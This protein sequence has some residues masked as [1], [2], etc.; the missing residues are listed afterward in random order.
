MSTKNVGFRGQRLLLWA[1]GAVALVS[2]ALWLAPSSPAQ[3]KKKEAKDAKEAKA[4]KA[5]ALDQAVLEKAVANR[6]I[7]KA[8]SYREQVNFINEQIEKGWLD[9]KVLPSPRCNDYEFIRRASLDIIGRIPTIAEIERF[10]RDPEDSRR[11]KLIDRLVESPECAD[12]FATIWTVMLLTRTGSGKVFKEQLREWLAGEL[13]GTDKAPPDWSKITTALLT[14]TGETNKNGAVNYILH[15]VGDEIKNDATANGKWDMI[16]VTSRTTRLFLGI[17]TQCVQCHDHP[18]NG[19]W[20]QHHFWGINAF[21]RQVDTNGRPTM[22][23]AKKKVKGLPTQQFD[24]HDNASYNVKGLVPYERRNGVLLVTDPTF[25][26]GKKM[27]KNAQITR[28]EQL[29]KFIT[30]SPSFAKAYVNRMWGHFMGKSFTKDS[31]DDF[32][33]HNPVSHPELLDKL[34]EEFVK[35]NHNPKV[36]ISWICNSR[37]YGLSS[38][39]NRYNDKN[40]DETLFARMLLKPMT[41]EQMFDSLMTATQ[42]KVSQAKEDKVALK[43][44]WL[45]LL[46]ANFGNDEGE[47][48]SFN[49]TVV[50]ALLLMNGKDINDAVMDK[51]NGTVAVVLKK[52]AFS[53]D[54]APAAIEELYLAALSRPPYT[55]VSIP[56]FKHLP[57]LSAGKHDEVRDLLSQKMFNFSRNPAAATSPQF[58]TGYYQDIFWALLNSNEFILNH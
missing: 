26:D 10:M 12:N 14:A 36:V 16:P 31:V 17:R 19:E 34:A 40:E 30:K 20:G 35:Y 33:E 55:T 9:N 23:V 37:S 56:S 48:G 58:W 45:D 21:F 1:A 18:F 15:H 46:T 29:A 43:E 24:V 39:A 7:D 44:Q 53:K 32:G 27:P 57:G 3:G 13:Q 6:P 38:V 47:E 50:Q 41:P 51:N 25:L 22:M 49:G 54:A 2:C 11:T 4:K 52:R 28:R 42:A 5:D 8:G